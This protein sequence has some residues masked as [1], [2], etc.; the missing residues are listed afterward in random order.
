MTDTAT[1]ADQIRAAHA[2]FGTEFVR[3]AVL[4][5][6]VTATRAEFDAAIKFL[7]GEPGVHVWGEVDQKTLTQYDR[8][9]GVYLGGTWRHNLYFEAVIDPEDAR[10]ARWF[11]TG[12]GYSE[13]TADVIADLMFRDGVE[14]TAAGMRDWLQLFGNDWPRE[15]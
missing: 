13:A 1:L 4:R 12:C 11:L 5:E 8:D 7:A 6:K 9:G 10:N 15:F 14:F 2:A 3:L